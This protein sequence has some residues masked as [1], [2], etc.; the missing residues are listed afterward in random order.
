MKQSTPR[1]LSFFLVCA[2]SISSLS[3]AETRESKRLRQGKIT[4]NEAQ[5]LVIKKYPGA[6][7]KKC[8]LKE[9]RGHSVWMIEMV[10]AGDQGVTKAE[11]DGRSGKVMP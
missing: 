11:V 4:K 9:E 5:H 6:R 8:M 7:I 3:Q 10:K 2:F 1:I